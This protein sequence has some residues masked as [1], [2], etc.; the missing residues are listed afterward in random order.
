[1]RITS[2][3]LKE[4]IKNGEK[5]LID[6][7]TDWCGPCKMMKPLFEKVADETNESGDVKL[8]LFNTEDDKDFAVNELEIRSV[9]TIKGISNGKVVFTE[10][11][12]KSAPLIKEM[13][14]RLS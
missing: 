12:I 7:Y 11:G 14:Q 13:I 9:P 2:E 8:Y 4:K 10:I 1:M 6:C 5:L 3:E